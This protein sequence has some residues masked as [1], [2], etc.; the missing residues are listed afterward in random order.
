MQ[1]FH[2]YVLYIVL[3]SLFNS[4]EEAVIFGYVNTARLY[5]WEIFI[6]NKCGFILPYIVSHLHGHKVHIRGIFHTMTEIFMYF[7]FTSII[8]WIKDARIFLGDN[9]LPINP[10]GHTFILL[11]GMHILLNVNRSIPIVIL[12]YEYHRVLIH[13]VEYYH[14]FIDIFIGVAMHYAYRYILSCI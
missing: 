8:G 11:N 9:K 1:V 2:A 10:S 6:V 7:V 5:A 3:Y 4:S 14:T 12:I 13:T